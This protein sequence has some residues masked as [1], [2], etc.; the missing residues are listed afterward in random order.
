MNQLK[1]NQHQSLLTLRCQNHFLTGLDRRTCQSSLAP[2]GIPGGVEAEKVESSVDSPVE[3][4]TV[5]EAEEATSIFQGE[6]A[7]HWDF[8]G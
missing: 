5:V 6:E 1:L 7:S 2:R 8:R 4:E 3:A